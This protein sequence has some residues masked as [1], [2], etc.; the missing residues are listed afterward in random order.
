MELIYSNITR[1]GRVNAVGDVVLSLGKL[2]VSL[3]SALFAFLMLDTH[4][5]RS[6]HDKVSSPLFPVTVRDAPT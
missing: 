3:C 1:I 5:Y 6:A 2:C 4:E